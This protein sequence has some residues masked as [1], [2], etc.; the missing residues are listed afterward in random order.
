MLIKQKKTSGK[1][2]ATWIS[3]VCLS[4]V[5]TAVLAKTETFGNVASNI[6]ATYSNIA[7]LVTG[8]SYIA[9]LG[10]AV[11]AVMKF[12]MHKD[13]PQ[14]TP[15]GTPVA[16]TFIAAALIFLPSAVSTTGAT[17]FGSSASVGNGAN[18][19]QIN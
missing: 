19:T 4:V 1:R 18:G 16:L 3:T 17:M 2:L 7:L 15:V 6:T 14:S 9:G 12:K 8:G 11:G 5:S 10:F 13:N